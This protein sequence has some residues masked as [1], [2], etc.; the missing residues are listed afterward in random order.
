MNKTLVV[1]NVIHQILNLTHV[2]RK[3][4][5]SQHK[6]WFQ[7]LPYKKYGTNQGKKES[8]FKLNANTNHDLSDPYIWHLLLIPIHRGPSSPHIC[9][10]HSPHLWYQYLEIEKCCTFCCV[11][12]LLPNWFMCPNNSFKTF[13][14][15]L[16]LGQFMMQFIF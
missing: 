5:V 10:F 16:E 11:V 15:F 12:L 14:D 4:F 8:Q 9:H 13:I 7:F 3:C 6:I 2:L 1:T